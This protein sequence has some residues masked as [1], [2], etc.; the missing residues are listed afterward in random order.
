[1]SIVIEANLK[2]PRV[3]TPIKDENGYPVD[4][5]SVRF[6][7][8]IEVTAIP[9]S[10]DPLQLKTASGV[11]LECTVTR[12]D[13]DQ[14]RELFV[15]SCSYAKRSIP[16]EEYTALVTDPSWVMRPLF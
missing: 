8:P 3:K 7:K 12:A 9:K 1:M 2:I 4:N 6:R 14:E 11:I 13:W 16:P 10:G 15:A 5:G